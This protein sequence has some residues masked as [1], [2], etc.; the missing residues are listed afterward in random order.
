[1]RFIRKTTETIIVFLFSVLVAAVFYQVAARYLF[2]S[3]PS[4]TEELARYCQA[5]II[6]LTSSICIRKGSHLAV[7]YF[8][9]RF[10]PGI[11]RIVNISSSVLIVVYTA[12][13]FIYGWRLMAAGQY[14]LSPALQV[15]MSFVYFIFPLSGAL[16]LIEALIKTAELIRGDR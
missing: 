7:D 10:N 8:G 5:W 6:L 9:H 1:M 3:P 15:K 2:N 13:V 16:M 12:V 11:K 4:W 14:Q